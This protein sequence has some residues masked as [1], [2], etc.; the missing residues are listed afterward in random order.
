LRFRF[1]PIEEAFESLAMMD[2]GAFDLIRVSATKGHMGHLIT[3]GSAPS[4]EK[5]PRTMSAES[6]ARAR[7]VH[8]IRVIRGEGI[9][10]SVSGA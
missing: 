6:R 2:I 9:I 10:K 8:T 3:H 7:P 5:P 1:R 4:P